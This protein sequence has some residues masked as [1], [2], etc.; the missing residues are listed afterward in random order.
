MYL[1]AQHESA[2]IFKSIRPGARPVAFHLKNEIAH[3]YL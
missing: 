2:R 3:P 1:V